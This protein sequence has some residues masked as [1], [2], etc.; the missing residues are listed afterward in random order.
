MSYIYWILHY[1][2]SNK[3]CVDLLHIYSEEE[4]TERGFNGSIGKYQL[5]GTWKI[6]L[7]KNFTQNMSVTRTKINMIKIY[8][9]ISCL[10]P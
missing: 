10:I 2:V 1:Y 4:Y 6:P 3:K 9:T 5:I 8:H 7:K